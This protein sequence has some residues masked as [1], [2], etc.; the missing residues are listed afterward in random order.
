MSRF[1][2]TKLFAESPL[3]WSPPLSGAGPSPPAP[4]PPPPQGAEVTP[5]SPPAPAGPKGG[6]A[7]CARARPPRSPPQAPSCSSPSSSGPAPRPAQCLRGK[8]T[9]RTLRRAGPLTCLGHSPSTRQRRRRRRR[10]RE[11][12]PEPGERPP[13]RAP[14]THL[15]PP[16]ATPGA[17]AAPPR[18]LLPRRP[19]Q[20]P[21]HLL[22]PRAPITRFSTR[23]CLSTRHLLSAPITHLSPWPLSS[24]PLLAPS[25]P[26]SPPPPHHLALLCPPISALIF[27]HSSPFIFQRP[28]LPSS[29]HSSP[30]STTTLR[31]WTP[32]FQALITLANSLQ[33]SS[34]PPSP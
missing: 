21:R 20:R 4:P 6:G 22:S 28:H 8:E 3:L 1:T 27:C 15:L 18:P 26:P 32:H 24:A 9:E 31:T 23:L 33:L 13:L 16:A 34:A 30:S 11:D 29:P 5:A 12:A 19:P 2:R 25:A 17:R 10:Q 14:V 7:G